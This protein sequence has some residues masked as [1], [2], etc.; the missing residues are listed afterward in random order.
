[1]GTRL[2]KVHEKGWY[3]GL[4]V[5]Q[6][7][8]IK[9]TL[10]VQLLDFLESKARRFGLPVA[11]YLRHLVLKDVGETQYPEF[12]M[13]NKTEKL[14][15]EAIKNRNRAVRVAGDTARFLDNL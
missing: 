14:L 13:S 11:A 1:M 6:Q 9:I 4:M 2:Y 3:N 5:T 8:Q 10:P 12:E 7:A 15:E